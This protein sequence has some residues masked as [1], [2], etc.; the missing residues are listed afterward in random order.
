MINRA[1]LA[2][3]IGQYGVKIS[4][5][6]TGKPQ[7][8]F[9]LVCSEATKSGAFKSFISVVVVGP[10]AETMA[11]TLEA[12]DLVLLEGKL[13]YKPGRMK[14]AGKLVVTTFAVQRLTAAAVTSPN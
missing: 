2:G 7:T 9:T 12:G 11:E 10:Q 4:W 5:T 8:S 6:E 3:E 1:V 14:E 13:Q